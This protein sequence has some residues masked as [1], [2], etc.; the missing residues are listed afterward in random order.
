MGHRN[1]LIRVTCLVHR[2][3]FL[4]VHPHNVVTECADTVT[5]FELKGVKS[6]ILVEVVQY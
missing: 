4:Y 3:T 1:Y 5:N 2:E 6:Y